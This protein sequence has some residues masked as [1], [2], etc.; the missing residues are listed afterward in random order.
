MRGGVNSNFRLGVKPFPLCFECAK[1]SMLYDAD[2]NGY[3]DHALGMGPVILGHADQSVNNAVKA[4]LAIGQLY[5]GQHEV[6][7]ALA[8]IFR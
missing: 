7:L 2:G 5:A 6:E 8:R 4:S 1:G 3:V